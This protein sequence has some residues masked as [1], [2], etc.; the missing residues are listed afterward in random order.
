MYKNNQV[1]NFYQA[2]SDRA[3]GIGPKPNTS[4]SQTNTSTNTSTTNTVNSSNSDISKI[5]FYQ[6][7]DE[8][9]EGYIK[10]LE[11]KENKEDA[12]ELYQDLFNHNTKLLDDLIGVMIKQNR[13]LYNE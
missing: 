5:L 10:K 13:K 9:K 4:I 12:K 1:E 11:D 2:T 8:E 3:R 7:S 6:L